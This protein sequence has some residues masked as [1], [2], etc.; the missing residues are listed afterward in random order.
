MLTSVMFMSVKDMSKEVKFKHRRRG[1][2]LAI[3]RGL[4]VR[5]LTS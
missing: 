1:S 3:H 4:T 2:R 5:M